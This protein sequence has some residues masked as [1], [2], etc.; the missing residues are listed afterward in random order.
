MN[1]VFWDVS[2][3]VCVCRR[4]SQRRPV[5]RSRRRSCAL[6]SVTSACLSTSPPSRCPTSRSSSASW[7]ARP[8]RGPRKSPRSPA[9]YSSSNR[10]SQ[11]H[12]Q[13]CVFGRR[14]LA[15]R[16]RPQLSFSSL[17]QIHMRFEME[18]ER[19]K[20]IHQKELEDKE[21]ELED[22]HKSSQRRVGRHDYRS[23]PLITGG[24]II[25]PSYSLQQLMCG[26]FSSLL[27]H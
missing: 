18:M 24:T 10:C 23:D 19:M 9:K 8:A 20:Q 5:C 3:W 2:V 16:C 17:R 13:T 21:E 4:A 6:R 15:R 27:S 12:V 14:S 25:C 7:R 1:R 11:K 26:S 22:V